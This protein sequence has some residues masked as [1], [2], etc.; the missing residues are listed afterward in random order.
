[1]AN[2]IDHVAA[3]T[4][5]SGS[6]GEFVKQAF[7]AA[8]AKVVGISRSS[9]SSSGDFTEISA[10]L[11]SADSAIAAMKAAHAINGRLDSL[12]H[13]VGGFA[14]GPEIADETPATFDAMFDVNVR[15]AFYAIRAVTPLMRA[16]GQGRMVL[17]ASRAAVEPSPHAALYGASKAALIALTRSVA[18]ENRKH[19][20]TANVVMPGT[21][22]MP[23]NREAM[24]G[25]DY[26][27]WVQPS[28]V[29][30]VIV[31]LASRAADSISGAA[32]PIFG[33]DV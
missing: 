5:V 29:A 9:S 12:I 33:S 27:K 13:L 26:S 31:F 16:A 23:K 19:R 25:A 6:L 21:M 28:Q 1:M 18:A 11:T 4:G 2:L 32:I 14:G 22:D 15:S 17:V 10:D 8:G 20:I 3:I 30:D 7:L 24:P